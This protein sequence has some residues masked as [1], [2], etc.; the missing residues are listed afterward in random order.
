MKVK[1]TEAEYTEVDLLFP[2]L[3][4]SF[5]DNTICLPNTEVYS[6]SENEFKQLKY[7]NRIDDLTNTVEPSVLLTQ[8]NSLKE[9]LNY[10]E[11]EINNMILHKEKMQD[12]KIDIER[13]SESDNLNN[14][15][16]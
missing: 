2:V 10:I 5:F 3:K 6:I 4:K 14:G 13:V 15:I 16:N 8:I 12:E 1:K 9:K 7:Y 11:V